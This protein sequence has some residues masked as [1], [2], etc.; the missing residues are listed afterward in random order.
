[1]ETIHSTKVSNGL[2]AARTCYRLAMAKLV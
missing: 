2:L 1:M